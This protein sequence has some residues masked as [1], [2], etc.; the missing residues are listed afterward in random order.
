MLKLS[1]EKTP[2]KESWSSRRSRLS[3]Q[4]P[5]DRIWRGCISCKTRGGT[6]AVTRGSQRSGNALSLPS[7]LPAW[8]SVL[9]TPSTNLVHVA[10]SP[11]PRW[12]WR[13]LLLH[14]LFARSSAQQL[15]VTSMPKLTLY[16]CTAA[17]TVPDPKERSSG[18]CLCLRWN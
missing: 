15:W 10:R 14:F 8:L 5:S 12:G 17:V 4:T 6:S 18:T 16:W 2:E 11:A 7:L 9:P 1:I 13:I 3:S